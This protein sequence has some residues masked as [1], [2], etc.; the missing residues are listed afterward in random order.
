MK[1]SDARP[2]HRHRACA[3]STAGEHNYPTLVTFE[4]DHPRLHP[5]YSRTNYEHSTKRRIVDDLPPMETRTSPL[6]PTRTCA[7]CE[8]VWSGDGTGN[9]GGR[10]KALRAH[11]VPYKNQPGHPHQ[12]SA[13][14]SPH[15]TRHPLPPSTSFDDGFGVSTTER[16][17]QH[18][19]G[20]KHSHRCSQSC[21]GCFC[22]PASSSRFCFR[23]RA[24]DLYQGTW[25]PVLRR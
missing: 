19:V 4:G 13:S 12:R 9:P 22:H 7:E 8:V 24:S 5:C 15:T 1:A 23:Q 10:P 20:L 18:S 2:R 3:T 16:A 17:G 6:G 25:F 14:S 21:E 11:G